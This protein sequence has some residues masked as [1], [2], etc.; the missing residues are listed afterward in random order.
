MTDLQATE[1]RKGAISEIQRISGLI[2]GTMTVRQYNEK[3]EAPYKFEAIR[4]SLKVKFNEL[5]AAAGLTINKNKSTGHRK[6]NKKQSNTIERR[7]NMSHCGRLFE[8]QDHMRSCQIC[9]NLKN[10]SSFY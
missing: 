4:D 10:N 2:T 3:A 1:Y 6:R 8:A 5:K 9:T 7:C